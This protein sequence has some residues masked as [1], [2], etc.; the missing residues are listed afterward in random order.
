[1]TLS[2]AKK[3][4]AMYGATELQG[5]ATFLDPGFLFTRARWA[6]IFEID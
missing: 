1:M 3:H 5:Q 2:P 4:M 6:I